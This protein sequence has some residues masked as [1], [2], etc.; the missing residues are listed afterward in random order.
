MTF[1]LA[2][3]RA[4]PVDSSPPAATETLSPLLML[5]TERLGDLLWPDNG[6][7]TP[8]SLYEAE[9]GDGNAAALVWARLLA[10]ASAGAHAGAF[11]FYLRNFDVPRRSLG[12]QTTFQACRTRDGFLWALALAHLTGGPDPEP[13]SNAATL[14]AELETF[15]T[16]DLPSPES[17]PMRRD[18][19]TLSRLVGGDPQ[20]AV[21]YAC[22]RWRYDHPVASARGRTL[23]QMSRRGTGRPI[24]RVLELLGA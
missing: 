21:I 12:G 8:F 6:S 23:Y 10:V 13:G 7:D 2:K 4:V 16:V 11:A 3:L 20:A 9:P 1:G 5:R 24:A 22:H 15:L 14:L 19:T 17:L 18:L